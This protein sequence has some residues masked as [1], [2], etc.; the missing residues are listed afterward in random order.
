MNEDKQKITDKRAAMFSSARQDWATP[1]DLFDELN[2]EF[3]FNLDPCASAEN[4]KCERYFTEEDNGLLQEWGG[5][6]VFCNPPYGAKSTGDWIEKCYNE[7]RKPET[8]VVMLIPARTDTKAFHKYIYKKAEV[9]FIKG[10]LKFGGSKDAAPF[11]SML[12]IFRSE[13]QKGDKMKADIKLKDF[14][15]LIGPAQLIRVIDEEAGEQDEDRILYKGVAAKARDEV[16]TDRMI[17][18]I[19]PEEPEAEGPEAAE[20][21]EKE[22][23]PARSVLKIY[24]Y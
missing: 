13:D 20:K 23:K 3:H 22:K 15:T 1:Q 9:R 16:D 21:E 14:F 17:K 6:S 10:R 18:F 2:E 4:H 7:S 11:P 5:S 24:I 12:V 8:V 19:I